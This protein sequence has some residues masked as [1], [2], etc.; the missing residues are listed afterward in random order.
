MLQTLGLS[1]QSQKSR[2]ACT[3]TELEH[4]LP[5]LGLISRGCSLPQAAVL[6]LVL[7]SLALPPAALQPRLSQSLRCYLTPTTAAAIRKA[8]TG[9]V[10]CVKGQDPSLETSQNIPSKGKGDAFV[11]SGLFPI[12]SFASHVL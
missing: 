2:D 11:L 4:H 6:L 9:E 3:R 8:A 12:A 1:S 10:F 7:L 5:P